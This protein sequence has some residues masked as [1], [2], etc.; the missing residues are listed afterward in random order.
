MKVALFGDTSGINQLIKYL[1]KENIF[2]LV[3]SYSR[4]QYFDEIKILSESLSVPFLIQPK[5]KSSEFENFL[6][7]FKK[8]EIDLIWSNS[9]SVLIRKEIIEL[10]SFGGINIHASYL[11]YNRGPNPIQWSIINQNKYT[12]VTLHLLDE[13]FDTG[14]IIDQIKIPISMSDNWLTLKEK[15]E[16]IIDLL[17]KKNYKNILKGNINTKKQENKEA[18]YN[19]RRDINDGFFKWSYSTIKIFNII[20]ALV[21]PLPGAFYIY[22]NDKIFVPKEKSINEIM[23]IKFDIKSFLY[24]ENIL[25]GLKFEVAKVSINNTIIF[26]KYFNKFEF[27][28][29]TLSDLKF[30]FFGIKKEAI[31]G[32]FSINSIFWESKKCIVHVNFS[33]IIE[34]SKLLNTLVE[35]SNFLK[36][37]LS[38]QLFYFFINKQKV[39]FHSS[40]KTYEANISC[41]KCFTITNDLRYVNININ[42]NSK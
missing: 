40:L 2:V 12:G 18:N 30:K 6:E 23:Q 10:S 32:Y 5:Y 8:L 19:R 42:L 41:F 25:S 26:K 22:K 37:E 21:N 34:E 38:L 35:I 36:Q 3:G 39:K 1:P 7:D 31:E 16:G 20:R 28:D 9:Y 33:E 17:I 24:Q 14:A 27:N 4:T 29:Q 11:P 13:S 15:I